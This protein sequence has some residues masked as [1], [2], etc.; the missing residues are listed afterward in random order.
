LG[1]AQ[2]S[3]TEAFTRS[4][5]DRVR[6]TVIRAEGPVFCA[7]LDLWQRDGA[8]GSSAIETLLPARRMVDMGL[9]DCAV[10]ADHLETAGCL[11]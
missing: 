2:L 4:P 1:L 9:I 5:A 6:V 3:L 7:G 10:P 8:I 11:P